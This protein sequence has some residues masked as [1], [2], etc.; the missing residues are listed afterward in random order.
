MSQVSIDDILEYTSN[1]EELLVG[2]QPFQDDEHIPDF[3]PDSSAQ[4]EAVIDPPPLEWFQ[5]YQPNTDIFAINKQELSYRAGKGFVP[6]ASPTP[7]MLQNAADPRIGELIPQDHPEWQNLRSGISPPHSTCLQLG[8]YALFGA[9]VTMMQ[10]QCYIFV[11]HFCFN[12]H[13]SICQLNQKPNPSEHTLGF[14][15]SSLLATSACPFMHC[16]LNNIPQIQNLFS[17][18]FNLFHF[19]CVSYFVAGKVTGSSLAEFLGLFEP[20]AGKALTK[21]GVYAKM[22]DHSKLTSK[23]LSLQNPKQGL[24][25]VEPQTQIFFDWGHKHEANGILSYLAANPSSVVHEVGFVLLDPMLQS[26][27]EEIC[28]GIN[29]AD[30]PVI[31]SS[32]DGIIV[33]APTTS[34][35]PQPLQASTSGAT[36]GHELP[37]RP[38]HQHTAV[39]PPQQHP[40][41]DPLHQ[42]WRQSNPSQ[43]R[44][45][46]IKAKTPFRPD[47]VP[48]VWRWLGASCKPYT[49]ILPQYFAQAQLNMLVTNSGSCHLLC[50]TVKGGSKVFNIPLDKHWCNQMLHWVAQLNIHY[51]RKGLEPP[52]NVFWEQEAYRGFVDMTRVACQRLDNSGVEVPSLHGSM[53]HPW[54][55]AATDA[56][57]PNTPEPGFADQLSQ[58]QLQWPLQDQLPP[59]C[60]PGWQQQQQLSQLPAAQ[61][62]AWQQQQQHFS[63]NRAVS[64]SI[65]APAAGDQPAAPPSL[66]LLA[67]AAIPLPDEDITMEDAHPLAAPLGEFDAAPGHP[68]QVLSPSGSGSGPVGAQ[69]VASWMQHICDH[70]QVDLRSLLDSSCQMALSLLA[71]ADIQRTLGYLVEEMK[72]KASALCMEHISRLTASDRKATCK[73]KQTDGPSHSVSTPSTAANDFGAAS[74]GLVPVSHSPGAASSGPGADGHQQPDAMDTGAVVADLGGAADPA[75]TR[76]FSCRPEAPG[77]GA[78]VAKPASPGSGAGAA[79]TSPFT[80]APGAAA[81]APSPGSALASPSTVHAVPSSTGIAHGPQAILTRPSPDAPAAAAQRVLWPESNDCWISHVTTAVQQPEAAANS[82]GGGPPGSRPEL[83]RAPAAGSGPSAAA[84]LFQEP[85]EVT[86]LPALFGAQLLPAGMAPNVRS[87][88]HSVVAQHHLYLAPHDFDAAILDRLAKMPEHK[89][90]S[91]LNQAAAASWPKVQNNTRMIMSWCVKWA[92]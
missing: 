86:A 1:N 49:K 13:L 32:P 31:G 41:V 3:V 16:V 51:V 64:P 25:V 77:L 69:G 19:Q 67:A 56:T 12:V 10:N 21:A 75:P 54:F 65:E 81:S 18:C 47:S 83:S 38:P 55:L 45:L 62:Q 5:G 66:R 4:Q 63:F 24:V 40:Q 58:Q 92:G 34:A 91:V 78:T 44:V 17:I 80:R 6:L 82:P 33:E 23:V 71:A 84:G 60:P 30:L 2:V 8:P 68:Q 46:E 52:Q 20:L 42:H 43:R 35:V 50:Y 48:G 85:R 57:V 36:A 9:P 7:Q 29:P 26:L 90:M 22:R 27:S 72:R 53:C 87:R 73:Q 79:A 15:T 70:H 74:N 89:A 76:P 39:P 14:C 37:V 88:L 61:Q 28:Q 59:Q 11:L